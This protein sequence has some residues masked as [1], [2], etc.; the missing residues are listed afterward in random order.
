MSFTIEDIAGV[1]DHSLLKPTMTIAEFE[2]GCEVALKHSVASVC[3]MPFFARRCSEIL[4]G[5]SVQSST[6]IGFPHGGHSTAAKQA[7]AEVALADGCQELDMVVNVNQVLSGNWEYVT[8]DISAVAK[9]THAA[10]AKL[11][12]IFENCYLNDDQKIQLCKICA[13]LNCDWV[14]TSTGFGTSGATAEDLELMVANTPEHVQVK[15][16]GGI[17]DLDTLLKFKGIGATRVGCSSTESLLAAARERL[18]Q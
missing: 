16:S 18:N 17:R 12:V 6:V 13:D 11:K 10:G 14:K 15:A 3:L 8:N 2:A 5:S 1:I 9:A 7:E 4:R